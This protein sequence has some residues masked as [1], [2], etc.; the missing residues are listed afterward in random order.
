MG[1]GQIGGIATLLDID[2]KNAA[3]F[4]GV[5][6]DQSEGQ[7]IVYYLSHALLFCLGALIEP[8][9]VL[10][11]AICVFGEKFKFEVYAGTHKFLI[12]TGVS[13]KARHVAIHKGYNNTQKFK[14]C[15]SLNLA[16]LVLNKPFSFHEYEPGA[17][18]IIN[19]LRY[20][21][22]S[23]LAP[24]ALE[25]QKC[26]YYGFGS[27]RNGYLLPLLINMRKVEVV[28]LPQERCLPM[29]NNENQLLCIQQI[30]CKSEKFGALCPDDVGSII[31]C[32]G[33]AVGMMVSRL[34]D[35]P[36]GV[37]FLDLQKNN[38]FITCG[39]DDS[40]DVITHD[41]D[42]VFDFGTRVQMISSLATV[43]T[44]A[45]TEETFENEDTPTTTAKTDT[46]TA[47]SNRRS[48]A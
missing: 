26:H 4:H 28:I 16:L 27:R 1:A 35:R 9:V 18:F 21:S 25:N 48:H 17:D 10:T 44:S 33:F 46:T 32:S 19:R 7:F 11:P 15:S 34:I 31:E 39:V 5:Q 30:P 2:F 14:E 12:N 41:D 3:G 45:E 22:S 6:A 47:Q 29:W 20:G 23:K 40:R 38:K 42:M 43:P 13:R 8:H 37:G 36:C 24:R